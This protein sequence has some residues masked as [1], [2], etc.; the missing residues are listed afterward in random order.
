MAILAVTASG[1]TD[2]RGG[3]AETS[4][5]QIL[6]QA[7]AAATAI[8][9]HTQFG[10]GLISNSVT[11]TGNASQNTIRVLAS[12]NFSAASWGFSA[13]AI[14]DVISIEGTDISSNGL[15]GSVQADTI[16]GLG[17]S[18]D[19]MTGGLGADT[20]NGGRGGDNFRYFSG[21]ELVAGEQVIGGLG[22]DALS[23]FNTGTIDFR[24]ATLSDI[25]TLDFV[26]GV[27]IVTMGSNQLGGS[28]IVSVSGSGA[29]DALVV[30][31]IAQSADLS[32]V[33]FGSWTDGA[34]TITVRG[35]GAADT[36]TG[37]AQNDT[38]DGSTGAD[39]THGGAGDDT[40]IVDDT[41]DT[42]GEAIGAGTDLVLSSVTFTIGA[43]DEIEKLT[44]TGGA[45]IDGTGNGFDN[46]ITGNDAANHLAGLAGKDTIDGAAGDDTIDGG[47][48]VD[49]LD[50][51]AGFDILD[52]SSR[53]EAFEI[54]LNVSGGNTVK[55]NGVLEDKIKNI[56]GAVGGSGADS[57]FGNF[58]AANAFTGGS[59][60][61]TF[62]G[63]LGPDT[64]DGGA[65]IDTGDYSH[66]RQSI[67]A[68]LN[69]AAA[70]IVRVQGLDEDTIKNIENLATGGGSDRLIGDGNDNS[71]SSNAG[72]DFLRGG[73]G[74]DSLNGGS[75]SDTA[76]YSDK[77][78][79]VKVILGGEVDATA[80]VNGAFED[81][82]RSIENI[83]G[84]S[85]GDKFTGDV[86]ANSFKGLGGKDVINGRGGADTADFSDKSKSLEVTLKGA[87]AT[88][89]KLKGV[90]DDSL[91]NVENVIGGSA[92]DKLI[93]D[94]KDNSLKGMGGK[95]T[96]DGGAGLD[97][98]DFSDK[99]KKVVVILN[100]ANAVTVKVKGVNEDTIKSIESV[101]G[102]SAGDKLVGD[103]NANSF[104]GMGGVDTINGGKGV[105]TADFSDQTQEIEVVLNGAT[106]V[107]VRIDDQVE[108]SLKNIENIIGGRDDDKLTGDGNANSFRG[109]GGQ[110]TIDGGG[111]AD[112]AD[113]SDKTEQ[114][115]VTLKGATAALVSGDGDLISNIENVIG[116]SGA[117]QL[118][119][120]GLANR[121]V[122]NDG[123]DTFKAGDGNDTIAGGNGNDVLSGAN[124]ADTFVFDTAL[125]AATN[126]DTIISFVHDT[127]VIE[128]DDAI[129]KKIGPKLEGKEFFAAAGAVAGHDKDDRIVYDLTTGDLRYDPDGKGPTAAILFA[130]LGDKPQTLS[131]GDFDIA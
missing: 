71:L 32:G 16:K 52:Y 79:K 19:T 36:L 9:D 33:T 23:L 93:G 60:N 51:G 14:G 11:M 8:F 96:V 62:V 74:H 123:N 10:A 90:N 54:N 88:T 84:G 122:G 75:G 115:S 1:T 131:A 82:L 126:V 108:D 13:W 125:S 117:D 109:M 118:G 44:L 77:T 59:G 53:F 129:F 105:D 35:S 43:L 28:T 119:G 103:G 81:T 38:I 78:K 46:T 17:N 124:G 101:I 98:A 42:V 120:D 40:F 48:G 130:T 21:N 89:V 94:A 100:G 97:T 116:G 83:V 15:I 99:T 70:T 110:D 68:V 45:A 47:A 56:E 25:E 3:A 80:E 57:F 127:D 22:A 91:K 12:A 49:A 24:L 86:A 69:G 102:G 114:V 64:L 7:P 87:T 50:G 106:A 5:D 55:V 85:A 121:L 63:G 67:E 39:Q 20:L 61:D 72:D 95:D 104:K 18:L 66:T 112:T 76:D 128:L 27:S 107:L 30:T 6:F 111:G 113:Y 34:D 37:S 65:G 58:S 92:A 26:G 4:I 73:G 31:A 29:A 41:G 2:F